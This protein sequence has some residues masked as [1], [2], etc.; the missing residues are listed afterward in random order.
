MPKGRLAAVGS[1]FLLMSVVHCS[2]PDLPSEGGECPCAP[3][4]TC[5]DDTQICRRGDAASSSAASGGGSATN[6]GGSGS[7]GGMGGA[8]GSGTGGDGVGAC[9]GANP[10]VDPGTI[11]WSTYMC[12]DASP[13]CEVLPNHLLCCDNKD[14]VAAYVGPSVDADFAGTLTS[15]HSYFVC[16]VTGQEQGDGNTVWY[17]TTL[18]TG[19]SWGFIAGASLL[20][21]GSGFDVTDPSGTNLPECPCP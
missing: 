12:P 21:G 2:I 19:S 4:Y 13:A 5:D 16:W 20:P 11:D 14:P 6:T 7:A 9:G 18:D 15:P 8:G 1:L 3:G 10:W 17:Y